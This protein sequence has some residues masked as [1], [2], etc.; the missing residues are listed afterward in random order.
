MIKTKLVTREV[1]EM[2]DVVCDIC[3]KSCHVSGRNHSYGT[4]KFSGCYGSKYDLQCVEMHL[5][6]ECTFEIV[7]RSTTENIVQRESPWKGMFPFNE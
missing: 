1:Y 5:C 2:E 3:Q 7:N 4:L 6:D